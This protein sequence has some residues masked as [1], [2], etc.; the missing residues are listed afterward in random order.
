MV[1]IRDEE[2]S[3]SCQEGE[4]GDCVILNTLD[5]ASSSTTNALFFTVPHSFDYSFHNRF[6]MLL[7]KG[8]KFPTIL[9]GAIYFLWVSTAVQGLGQT[10]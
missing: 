9:P 1:S 2:S 5:S 4:Q 7:I 6:I 10:Q 8:K 3:S